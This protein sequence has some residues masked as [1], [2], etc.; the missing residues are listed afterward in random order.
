[1]FMTFL[2][3]LHKNDCINVSMR[4]SPRPVEYFYINQTK[5]NIRFPHVALAKQKRTFFIRSPLNCELL[6]FEIELKI[7]NKGSKIPLFYVGKL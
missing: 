5:P 1:M 2:N 7:F 4:S 3:I 6:N